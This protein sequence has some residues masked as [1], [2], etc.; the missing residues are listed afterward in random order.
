MST[1]NCRARFTAELPRARFTILRDRLGLAPGVQVYL[2]P[3]HSVWCR[4]R[5]S[6]FRAADLARVRCQ[7]ASRDCHM[8]LYVAV[9][10]RTWPYVAVCGC[11]WLSVAV[12]GRSTSQAARQP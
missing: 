5:I 4:A 1:P 9:R 2:R 7:S 6:R 3:R 8:W 12:C 10:G 11:L